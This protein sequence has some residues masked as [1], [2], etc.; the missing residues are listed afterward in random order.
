MFVRTSERTKEFRAVVLILHNKHLS[1]LERSSALCSEFCW[2]RG[3]PLCPRD[4]SWG[5]K[6]HLKR[7]D[8]AVWKCSWWR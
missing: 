6:L 2:M 5:H 7:G 4:V 8:W 3:R 1:S